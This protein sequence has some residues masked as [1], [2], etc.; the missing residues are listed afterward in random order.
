MIH[1]ENFVDPVTGTHTNWIEGFW[2]NL[3]MKL[4]SIRGSQ[5]QMLDGHMDEFM[6][7]FNRKNEGCI[8]KL[9]M[10]DIALYYPI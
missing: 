8:L 1:K 9:M 4:K 6:Y 10:N 5:Q 7:R 2:G 3:K